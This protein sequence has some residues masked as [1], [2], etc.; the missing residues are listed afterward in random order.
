ML[1]TKP[2]EEITYQDVMDF[3]QQKYRENIYLD[4]KK[5]IDNSSLAKTIAAMANTWGGII[6]IGVDEE[7][8]K[9]KLPVV[10]L[11]YVEHLREQINNII[12][13]NIT[14]PVFPEIQVCEPVNNKIFIVVRVIQ[15]NFTPHATKNNTKV[16]LRTDTSNEPEEL[17]TVDR[18]LWLVDKRDKS[19]K[20]KDSFYSIAEERYRNLCKEK[21]YDGVP[22]ADATLS[23]S[24]AFPFEN[25]MDVRKL[26]NITAEQIRVK[27]WN[28]FELP[29][30]NYIDNYRPI[31]QGIY[32]FLFVPK[33][34]YV[35]YT[36]LNQFGFYLI[37]ADLGNTNKQVD[38]TISRT[39]LSYEILVYLDLFFE[40][41]KR[42][43]KELGFWGILEFQFRLEKI[44][45]DVIFEGLPAPKGENYVG[46]HPRVSC[47]DKSIR[48]NKQFSIMELNNN[49]H[50]ILTDLFMDISWAIGY[51]RLTQELLEKIIQENGDYY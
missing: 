51:H 9:P 29:T 45:S 31:Q 41:A 16:Y 50:Q 40:S 37:K 13:G 43:Y 10:G 15:S 49:K 33:N 23:L 36:E 35:D 38:G 3:C 1:Y 7:D 22:F 26:R 18:I 42:L 24:P 28:G 14:P 17:A 34:Q 12:L 46:S 4:Y 5:Q 8:S 2:I 47:T 32:K 20:L 39:C 25:L 19:V 30:Q 27:G 44:D 48:F 11:E 6:I 21:N